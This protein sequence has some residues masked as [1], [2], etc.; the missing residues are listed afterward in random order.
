[1]GL[2]DH[3]RARPTALSGGQAQRVALARALAPAPRLLLLDEPLS[4]LDAG[5]RGLVRTELRRHLR[6]FAG[7]TVLVTHDPLDAMVLADRVVVVERGS[8]VQTGPPA[9]V[10]RAPRTPYVAG[11]VGLNLYRGVVQSGRAALDGGGELQAA[12]APDGPVLLTFAPS[13][14]SLHRTRPEGSAR[15]AWPGRVSGVEHHGASVRVAVDARPTVLADVTTAAVAE[16]DLVPGREVWAS[17]KATEVHV[18]P[19]GRVSSA[20]GRRELPHGPRGDRPVLCRL[21]GQQHLP[22]EQGVA[23]DGR[24]QQHRAEVGAGRRTEGGDGAQQDQRRLPPRHPP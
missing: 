20:G 8:V 6:E 2:A 22:G 12:G 23:E 1:M 11:L 18:D 21:L 7:C 13:A 17:V 19:L 4:A 15:N 10:A 5:A 24:R 16:L 3:A 14:V 9:Q